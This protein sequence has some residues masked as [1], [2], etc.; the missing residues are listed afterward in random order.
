MLLPLISGSSL[1]NFRPSGKP[2]LSVACCGGDTRLFD[3][4]KLGIDL[5]VRGGRLRQF[6]RA[7]GIR[8]KS[9]LKTNG[10]N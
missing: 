10:N 9:D 2:V 7:S 8:Q 5:R 1:I 3:H 6:L 4:L